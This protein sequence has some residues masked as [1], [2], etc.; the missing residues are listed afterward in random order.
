MRTGRPR[1]YF[2]EGLIFGRLT[3]EKLEWPMWLCMC[4]CGKKTLVSTANLRSGNTT[5]CGC[6]HRERQKEVPT[7]HGGRHTRLYSVW[8]NMWQRCTNPANSCWHNYGGRGIKISQHWRSFKRFRD[9]MGEAPEGYTLERKDNDG[10][11]SKSNCRWATRRDQSRNKRVNRVLTFQGKS[12]PLVDWAELL[13][14]PY[15]TLHA[16]LRRGWS[17]ERTL[18]T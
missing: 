13:N 8:L 12:L 17:T 9:D 2:L 18:S 10:P 3:V 15:W 7:K 5:S 11:Y 16:R 4:N 6:Y 1:Q 14:K